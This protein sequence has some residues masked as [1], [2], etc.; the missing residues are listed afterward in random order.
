MLAEK[1]DEIQNL[2]KK[3]GNSQRGRSHA[4]SHGRQIDFNSFKKEE[5]KI[6]DQDNSD[7][8]VNQ[9]RRT[10][11]FKNSKNQLDETSKAYIKNI[12]LKYLEY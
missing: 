2:R 4:D 7:E 5:D 10:G 12:L 3:Y 1:N 9:K 6:S 11:Q 8:D